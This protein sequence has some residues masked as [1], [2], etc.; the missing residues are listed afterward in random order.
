MPKLRGLRSQGLERKLATELPEGELPLGGKSETSFSFIDPVS[1]ANAQTEQP[2]A[3]AV[4]PPAAAQA[5]AAPAQ[6][7]VPAPP[8]ANLDPSLLGGNPIDAMRNLQ[9]AQRTR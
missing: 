3:A 1:D 4:P 6:M 7:A 8:T 5:G 2:V 9:I